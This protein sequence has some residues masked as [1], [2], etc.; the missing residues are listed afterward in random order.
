M[1]KGVTYATIVGIRAGIEG[2]E[3]DFAWEVVTSPI[4]IPFSIWLLLK[5]MLL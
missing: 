2:G 5:L 1:I 4:R 3:I